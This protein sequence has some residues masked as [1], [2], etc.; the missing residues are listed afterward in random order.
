MSHPNSVF[1]SATLG[2]SIAA[3]GVIEGTAEATALIVKVFS[4][5]LSDRIEHRKPL[6]VL[7]YSLAAATK[8]FFALAATAEAVLL[9]RLVD[10]VGKGVPEAPRDAMIADIVGADIRGAAF[11]LRQALTPSAR[12]SARPWPSSVC[13]C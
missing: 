6:V 10:R 13:R 2:A 1:L 4:G 8:P 5:A 12:F 9:T 3:V 7:G 11:G